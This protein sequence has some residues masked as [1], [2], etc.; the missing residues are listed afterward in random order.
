MATTTRLKNASST[1]SLPRI[2][3]AIQK[4]LVSHK[5]KYV[6]YGYENERITSVE[7]VID[8]NGREYPFRL[9]ARIENVQKIMYPGRRFLSETQKTQIYRTAWANIRDWIGAQ[10]AMIDTG[11]VRPEEI[12]LP[13]MVAN[14]GRT[15]FE[16]MNENQFLLPSGEQRA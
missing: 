3:E 11:M 10:M 13:Y 12:F 2:F 16:V 5:A 4:A 1:A 8:I 9:P 15:F 14:D 6:T 7:F